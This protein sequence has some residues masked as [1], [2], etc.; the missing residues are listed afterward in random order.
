MTTQGPPSRF[1]VLLGKFPYYSFAAAP[2]RHCKARPEGADKARDRAPP[3]NRRPGG[4]PFPPVFVAV[5]II[6]GVLSTPIMIHNYPWRKKGCG[7]A[8]L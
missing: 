5:I 1:R 3:S 6:F 2:R 7:A 4:V 8:A